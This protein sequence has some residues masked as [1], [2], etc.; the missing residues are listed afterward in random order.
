MKKHIQN[1]LLIILLN[2]IWLSAFSQDFILD[3]RTYSTEEGLAGNLVLQFMEDDRGFVWISTQDGI[4][5]F[6]GKSFKNFFTDRNIFGIN[7]K[8]GLHQD[9]HGNIWTP[10]F[11][12]RADGNWYHYLIDTNF[13][14]KVI[15][16]V[17]GD[18]MPFK[19]AEI[20]N[21]KG[22]GGNPLYFV[23]ES[24]KIY[25]FDGNFT[26]IHS[27][28]KCANRKILKVEPNGDI[29]L[30]NEE[31][32]IIIDKQG[33]IKQET[34]KTI[35]SNWGLN[36]FENQIIHKLYITA[37]TK[38][39][40]SL[41]L[42]LKE[43]LQN[44]NQ[45]RLYVSRVRLNDTVYYTIKNRTLLSLYDEDFNLIYNF[46]ED[47]RKEFGSIYVGG[48]MLLRKN[49]LWFLNNNGFCII[50][51]QP[52]PF[53]QYQKDPG[54]NS[55][56]GI[57]ITSDNRFFC[58]TSRGFT[59]IDLI[60][61]EIIEDIPKSPS[62]TWGILETKEEFFLGNYGISFF[63][64]N[65]KE[66]QY[67]EI[68][69]KKKLLTEKRGVFSTPFRDKTGQ[70]YLGTRYGLLRY[71]ASVD[72][73][74]LFD[75]YNEFESLKTKQ[76]YHFAEDKEGGWIATSDGLYILD[77]DKGIT[78]YYEPAPELTITHFYREEN[79]FWLA[80]YGK[81]LIKWNKTTG[82]TTR[83]GRDEGFL[84]E[85]LTAVYPDK[86]DHLWIATETGVVRFDKKTEDIRVFLKT[87]GITHNEFNRGSHF[88]AKDGMIYFGGLNG[89]TAF[90]P[91][92]LSET[93]KSIHPFRTT[94]Y[95]ELNRE[96]G[97]F[98][99]KTNHLL[100][101]NQIQ[102]TPDIK[103]FRIHFSLLN[104]IHANKTQYA[105]KIEGYDQNWNHQN[106][107]FIRV[108][109]LPYGNYTLKIKAQSYEGHWSEEVISIP[110]FVDIPFYE[111]KSW[112]LFGL[113]FISFLF[114][115]RYQWGQRQARKREIELEKTV[116]ERTQTINAQKQEL[117]TLNQT[118]DRLFSIIGHDLR[119][120]VIAFKGLSKK[121]AFLIQK[122]ET[123]RVIGLS[124]YIEKEAQYLHDLLDNLLNWALSQRN[125]LKALKTSVSV[126]EI[127]KNIKKTNEHL[128]EMT[129][130]ELINSVPRELNVIADRPIL[131][132]VF[133]NLI[134]NAFRHTS[135][136]DSIEIRCEIEGD[137]VNIL[138][139]D[140]GIGMNTKQLENLFKIQKNHSEGRNISFG[141]HLCHEL[142]QLLNGDITVSSYQKK[143]TTFKI[144]LPK[145]V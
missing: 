67:R 65:K 32:I 12:R 39:Y 70:I 8:L 139:E 6:D 18:K 112:Q 64:Y 108:N 122:N 73:L 9:I 59:E 84:N 56:R 91:D 66:K 120:P 51:Y 114:W 102:L 96:T 140:N 126:F 50:D 132:T 134:S 143:G 133:R 119:D 16:E 31:S 103:S 75:Q 81:G 130:V 48:A 52:N 113:V 5:R 121:I 76:V 137:D 10:F 128:E 47:L 13:Q 60:T 77:S 2:N 57:H 118:K 7:T 124:N 29:H 93:T 131:E 123:E 109:E 46:S 24:G 17:Y 15:D 1:I 41:F 100:E 4:S 145:G 138:V 82:E 35:G 23:L 45:K 115:A 63:G 11:Q 83:F 20:F 97:V 142:I 62:A 74:D 68:F 30:A 14:V 79:I 110:I 125:E 26:E 144:T 61:G 55:V 104:Y 98:E 34:L 22:N 107:N 85:K 71:D 38:G 42:S 36:Q 105:Y 54:T 19:T 88:K 117:L 28:P 86:N 69:L 43:D 33:Q 136:D 94:D 3:F 72:S 95:Y 40:D 101:S 127:I 78:E 141:L 116:R 111:K 92:D 129:G 37:K 25:R 135:K 27:H 53:R 21:I 58:N 87:D 106:E 49:Q 90:H 44:K 89:I 80:T 99:E